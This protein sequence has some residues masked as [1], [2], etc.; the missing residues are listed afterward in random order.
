MTLDALASAW[1]DAPDH[2]LDLVVAFGLALPIGWD[3]EREERSAGLRT[4]PL[5]AIA[6]CA[7][8]L[9][10]SKVLGPSSGLAQARILEGLITGV[11][12]IGGGAIVKGEGRVSGTATAAALWA[13]GALGIAVA[14]G[15]Y[16][17]AVIL[18]GVTFAMLR[19]LTPLKRE[20]A[21]DHQDKGGAERGSGSASRR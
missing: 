13:T 8:V 4:F 16:D 3:R 12:F 2:L 6:A 10:A 15:L 1:T 21:A 20:Q 7:F 11:G 17:M 18:S 19:W 5:V 9:I 14:Y